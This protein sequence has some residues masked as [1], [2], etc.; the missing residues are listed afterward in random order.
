MSS[1][2]KKRKE[3]EEAEQPPAKVEKKSSSSATAKKWHAEVGTDGIS[4]CF[5]A[6]MSPELLAYHDEEWGTVM[7]DDRLL[8]EFLVLDGA[9]AGLNWATIM[10][11][12]EGYRKAFDNFDIAKVASYDTK[13]IELLLQ[14]PGIIRN[15][16]KVTGA[17]KTAKACL[18]I[19]NEF[20]SLSKYLW[21]F[22]NHKPIK[23]T[24]EHHK[25]GMLTVIN[26]AEKMS[27]DLK[28]RG[29]SFVGPTIMY[30]FMQTVGMVN[31]HLEE[32]FRWKDL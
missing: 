4:R 27:A 6:H 31:D 12:R 22:V 29:A 9:Q 19:Q 18:D 23:H 7:R 17:V 28:E 24:R 16:A 11:K 3:I 14:D 20:G 8:F 15:R 32:C 10:K 30:A 25:N 26:E 2:R 1:T 21:S 5:W 13:K